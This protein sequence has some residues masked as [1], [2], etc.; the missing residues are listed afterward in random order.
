[1]MNVPEGEIFYQDRG[2]GETLIPGEFSEIETSC[3]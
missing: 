2:E 3:K 1:M